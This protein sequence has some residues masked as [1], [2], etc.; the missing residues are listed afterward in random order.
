[1]RFIEPMYAQLV[2]ELPDGGKWTYAAKL[3]GYPSPQLAVLPPLYKGRLWA[4]AA[5]SRL[6]AFI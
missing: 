5:S 4:P 1:V 2:R 3:D 6:R